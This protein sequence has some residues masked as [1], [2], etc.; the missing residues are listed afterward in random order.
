MTIH[1]HPYT[2]TTAPGDV[3]VHPCPPAGD[4]PTWTRAAAEL[5]DAVPVDVLALVE[6]HRV[7]F[8]RRTR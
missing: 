3:Q 8:R 1:H 6:P 4:L 7:T 5:L 2:I